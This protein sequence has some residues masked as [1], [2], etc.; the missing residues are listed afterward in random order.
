M[1]TLPLAVL[2]ALLALPLAAAQTMTPTPTQEGVAPPGPDESIDESGGIPWY[3]LMLLL[4]LAVGVALA[5]VLVK[6]RREPPP[7]RPPGRP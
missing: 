4:S 3:G 5:Y 7:D 6:Q 1:R 2:A